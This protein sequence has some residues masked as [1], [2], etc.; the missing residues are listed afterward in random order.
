ML[1]W[2]DL[3]KTLFCLLVLQGNEVQSCVIG[4]LQTGFCS[5]SYCFVFMVVYF[6][7]TQVGRAIWAYCL[8]LHVVLCP[9]Q[10]IVLCIVEVHVGW[11]Y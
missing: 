7:G 2:A 9:V 4:T 3:C 6:V 8:V 10:C 11:A 1:I 5:M